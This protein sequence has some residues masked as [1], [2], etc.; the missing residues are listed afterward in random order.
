MSPSLL[1]RNGQRQKTV[2]GAEDRVVSL[3][4]EKF[5]ELYSLDIGSILDDMFM[6]FPCMFLLINLAVFMQFTV[7]IIIS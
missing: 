2:A 6:Q 3:N 4:L 1:K 5:T 7:I